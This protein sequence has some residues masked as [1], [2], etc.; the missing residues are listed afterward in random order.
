M[1]V[2]RFVLP[3]LL[4]AMMLEPQ[5]WG[6]QSKPLVPVQISVTTYHN[7]NSRTGQNTHETILTPKNV[8]SKQFGK[9]FSQGVDGFIYGQPLY[10]ANVNV[11][12][13]GVHNV[14]Y[15]ATA[16]DGLYAFDADDD[17]GQN[18]SPLWQVSFI[19]APKVKTVSINDVGGCNNIYPEIGII[20]TPVID[21]RTG[22]LYVVVKTRESGNFVQRLHAI[23]VSNGSEKFGGP[24]EVYATYPGTGDGSVNGVITF[25]PLA[26]NQ[27]PG[28]LLQDDKVY[29]GWASHC[30]FFTYH[31]WIMAYTTHLA[32]VGVWNATPAGG[33]GGVWQSG[34]APAG[35]SAFNTYF[36]TGNGTFDHRDFGDSIVKLSTPANGNFSIL[37]FFT[38]YNQVSLNSGDVDLGS[39]GVLLV[40]DQP[41]GSPHQHLLLQAGKEG[42]IYL[43]DRDHMGHF[44]AHSNDQIVQSLLAAVGGMWSMPAWWN[45]TAYFA[46]TGD[47]LKAYAFDPKSGLLSTVPISQ[48]SMAFGYP[49]SPTVSAKGNTNGIVW[50][51]QGDNYYDSSGNPGHGPEVLYAW[52]AEDLSNLLYSSQH[53]AARDGAGQAMEYAV[54]TIANGKV[55]VGAKRQIS[56][57]GLLK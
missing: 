50:L 6:Q 38:P 9:L 41:P 40:P 12:G 42:T 20:G 44:N 52:D 43:V 49:G 19:N 25:D 16:H 24:V 10:L 55:Y 48:T 33:L 22:T 3:S 11:P 56:V 17:L 36:A 51:V 26:Q 1:K 32:Q 28:L 8:N 29:I 34:A 14:I 15:V 35:D 2:P 30:D 7:D 5:V 13:K 53:N 27:R 54:P 31:G 18:A 37:D 39:G 47:A 21:R 57:Y 23:D 46:G 45:N 4:L